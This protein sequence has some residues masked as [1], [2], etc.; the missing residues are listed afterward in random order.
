MRVIR[1]ERRNSTAQRVKSLAHELAH[2]ILH[3]HATDRARAELEAESAAYVIC[4]LLGIDS[5]QYSFGYVASWLGDGSRASEAI[6]RSCDE[7]TR[8]VNEVMSRYEHTSATCV[9]A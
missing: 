7:I 9:V 5:G 2:A 3:E 8:V 4:Q 6:H 1:V